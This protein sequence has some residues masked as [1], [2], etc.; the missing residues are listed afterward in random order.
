MQNNFCSTAV[1]LPVIATSMHLECR[2]QKEKQKRC[3]TYKKTQSFPNLFFKKK[4]STFRS[5]LNH[6][7]KTVPFVKHRDEHLVKEVHCGAQRP[8][9][10]TDSLEEFH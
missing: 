4:S 5:F 7:H 8:G 10:R 2:L 6:A 1:A 3:N 9:N